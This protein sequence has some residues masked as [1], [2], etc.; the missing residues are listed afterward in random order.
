MT[1]GCSIYPGDSAWDSS[2]GGNLKYETEA[3]NRC[4][5]HVQ[6]DNKVCS[7]CLNDSSSVM[8]AYD[9]RFTLEDHLLTIWQGKT[10]EFGSQFAS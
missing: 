2:K 8:L 1:R 6:T 7:T 9:Q 4:R 3:S 5:S 10:I